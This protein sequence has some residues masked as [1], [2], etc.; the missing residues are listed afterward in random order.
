MTQ[1]SRPTRSDLISRDKDD[2]NGRMPGADSRLRRSTV[3]ALATMHGGALDGA[4]GYLDYIADQV[5]PDSADDLHLPRIASFWGVTPKA[6]TAASGP[7]ASTGTNGT[8][9]PSGSVLQRGDGESY[10]TTALATVAG[11]AITVN[12]QAV[13]PGS[14]GD[15][16]AG[17]VLSLVSPVDGVA[18]QF[19]V[20]EASVAGGFDAETMPELLARLEQRVQNPPQGGGPGDYVGW[21]LQMPG[22]TRAWEYPL[23]MGLGTVGLAFVLDDRPD[24]FPLDADVAA[25]Q[26]WL[27]SFAPVT[28]VP[29]AFAPTPLVVNFTLSVTPNTSP[30]QTAVEAELADFFSRQAQPGSPLPKSQ[31]DQAISFAAGETDHTVTAP[32]GAITPTPGQ[33]PTLGTVTFT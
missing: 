10:A 4:Y 29:V 19:T 23:W 7:A 25:M 21:A 18:S 28:A 30:V 15:C 26:A 6:P 31:Y 12:V 5:F 13:D 1:F 11:G 17:G 3:N 16:D 33:L 24:I 32:A 9:L 2:L 8:P 20:G 27:E 22:V 14:A